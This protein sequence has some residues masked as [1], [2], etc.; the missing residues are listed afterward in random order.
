[1]KVKNNYISSRQ[2]P[3]ITNIH[4]IDEDYSSHVHMLRKD[5]TLSFSIEFSRHNRYTDFYDIRSDNENLKRL[6][7]FEDSDY[8]RY[9]F[10]QLLSWTFYNLISARKTYM[11]IVISKNDDGEIVGLS[12]APFDAK[13]YVTVNGTSY[14]ISKNHEKKYVYFKIPIR[15]YMEFSLKSLGLRNNYFKRLFQKLKRLDKYTAIGFMTDDKMK[16]KFDSKVWI[17][18]QDYDVLQ[19][20][21]KIGW[22]G[23]SSDN[24]LLSESYLLYRT[25][26]YK[27]FR[28]KCMK[29]LLQTI[30]KTLKLI[31]DEIGASGEI[32]VAASLLD[33]KKEWQR[34]INGEICASELSKIIYGI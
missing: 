16:S 26:E 11:E 24:K 31:S 3:Y 1:M 13:K 18:K 8:F 32:I 14:F 29:Y 2:S 9:N 34:Y 20:P 10:D 27:L 28:Q 12:L 6:F 7:L 15:H 21:R 5:L 30:N 25:I 22:H 17:E 4:H 23:R 19:Y 33:Y